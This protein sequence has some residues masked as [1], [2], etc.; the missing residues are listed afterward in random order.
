MTDRRGRAPAVDRPR[1]GAPQRRRLA[2]AP[3]LPRHARADLLRAALPRPRGRAGAGRSTSPSSARSRSSR[4]TPDTFPCLRLAREAAEAGGTAPCVLNAANEIAVH[5]FL[6]GD[7]PFTGIARVI[8]STLS[9]LPAAAGAPL[10]RPLRGGRRRR[11][12]CAE[13]VAADRVSWFL[14]FA[15]F[16]LLVILHELGPLQRGQGGRHA[17]GEVLAVLPADAVEQEGGGDRVRDRR[18]P[19]GRLREDQRDEPVR[20]PARGGSRPRLPRAAGLEAD[21]RDRG[22]AGGQPR[23]GLRAAVRLL[24]G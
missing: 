2:R 7:L 19:R 12:R 5:A 24:R 18:D 10:L 3:G 9:E 20:G 4:P 11:A 15:G 13:R 21:R 1:A 22:G 16:A 6:A 23:A 8:E 14:A 17:R